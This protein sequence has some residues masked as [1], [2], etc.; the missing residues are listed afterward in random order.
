VRVHVDAV[1]PRFEIEHAARFPLLEHDVVERESADHPSLRIDDA[2]FEHR[3]FVAFA[4]AFDG[5]ID[6]GED[7]LWQDVGE[8]TEPA[9]VDAD[10]RHVA[11]GDQ[12]GG[13]EQGAVT[14]DRD[15]EIRGVRDFLFRNPLDQARRGVER[16][17]VGQKRTNPTLLQMRE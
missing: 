16:I 14:A 17:G 9:A 10:E 5:G 3:P 2:C 13:I 1:D 6:R 8:E 7:V 11:M 15:D 12:P 4:A